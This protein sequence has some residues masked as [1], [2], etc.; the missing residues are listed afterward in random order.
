VHE[1]FEFCILLGSSFCVA[2]CA[3]LNM[4]FVCNCKLAAWI[5]LRRLRWNAY[6]M[7]LIFSSEVH[8]SPGDFKCNR[9]P[10]V[11]TLL[12]KNR[13]LFRVGA[14][15]LYCVLKWRWIAI[16]DYS[17][18]SHNM[19]WIC[20]CGINII[21]EPDEGHQPAHAH[22]PGMKKPRV[23]LSDDIHQKPTCTTISFQDINSLFWITFI[24]TSC[25]KLHILTSAL[26]K[27]VLSLTLQLALYLRDIL[28]GAV[29]WQVWTS[30]QEI[31]PWTSS[32]QSVILQASY[33]DS[34][35][36]PN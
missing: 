25:V 24:C 15:H 30:L 22:K 16:R 27:W 20:S 12:S 3:L 9:L 35:L 2:H 29:K 21:T 34:R 14:W 5:D 13:M 28:N 36:Q 8:V 18:A 19:H 11:L 6:L 4:E 7:Q 33:H 10:A 23:F 1:S 32:L 17:S 26:D 31:K